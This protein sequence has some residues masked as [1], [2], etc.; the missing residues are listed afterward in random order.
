MCKLFIKIQKFLIRICIN[1]IF[2]VTLEVFS[3]DLLR[4]RGCI[5]TA[6]TD[7]QKITVTVQPHGTASFCLQL[8][9]IVDQS[10]VAVRYR[11]VFHTVN[12]ERTATLRDQDRRSEITVRMN[13]NGNTIAAEE[14]KSLRSPE[15]IILA[16][17][18]QLIVRL[19]D[20][21]QRVAFIMRSSIVVRISHPA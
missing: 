3:C 19:L 17:L 16:I 14:Q 9:E 8:A 1:D 2:P 4:V 5:G 13:S 10:V 15:N 21:I 6:L 18:C 11:L 20:I 7:N 12:G